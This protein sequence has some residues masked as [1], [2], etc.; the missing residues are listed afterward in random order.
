MGRSGITYSQVAE[1][2]AQ[3]IEQGRTPTVDHVRELLCTGSK[4]TLSPL[5]KR[6]KDSHAEAV[7]SAEAGVPAPLLQAIQSLYQGMQHEVQQQL[8]VREADH[9]TQMAAAAQ[10][11]VELAALNE[12]L[13]DASATLSTEI[14]VTRTE[15]TQLY[16]ERHADAVRAAALTSD[17]QALNL[18]L[19]D[20]AAQVSTLT[21]QLDQNRRQF[22][23][24]Q[25]ATARQR[26]EERQAA[27]LHLQLREQALMS[28]QQQLANLRASAAQLSDRLNT[29]QVDHAQLGAALSDSRTQIAAL[30]AARE[31]L[32]FQYQEVV[33]A[34]ADSARRFESVQI[35]LDQVRAAFVEQ[36]QAAWLHGQALKAADEKII[37]LETA[38]QA[39]A[40]SQDISPVNSGNS[41]DEPHRTGTSSAL[42]CTNSNESDE[43]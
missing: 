23:H 5:L 11:H 20:H 10:H 32:T 31:Q 16:A 30:Q 17:N 41:N 34:R 1:A 37:A 38:L 25:E 12:Q 18:R 21:H 2:A 22:D 14:E 7:S 29:T 4:S 15:L 6:W 3:L 42:P 33:A 27:D 43:N 9:A 35:Q 24:Y 36:Q 40:P 19:S 28:T 13:Q 39:P 8:T 26:G